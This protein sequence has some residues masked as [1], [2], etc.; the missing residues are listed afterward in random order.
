MK[1]LQA[2]L[3]REFCRQLEEVENRLLREDI[4]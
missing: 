2:L 1:L 4:A 3:V